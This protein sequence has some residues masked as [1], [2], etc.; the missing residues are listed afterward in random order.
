MLRYFVRLLAL[1]IIAGLI[2]IGA[3]WALILI[4]SHASAAEPSWRPKADQCWEI[5]AQQRGCV[6]CSGAWLTI[7]RCAAKTM[8][9]I[10]QSDID[11]CAS[12]VSVGAADQPMAFD[13]V[14][15]TFQCLGVP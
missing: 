11:T 1:Y 3:M 14:A 15:A 2:S 7:V 8:P 6:S 12:R 10:A 5:I 4:A 13:R 9:S